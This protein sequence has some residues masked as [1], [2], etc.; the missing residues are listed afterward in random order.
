MDFAKFDGPATPSTA[1]HLRQRQDDHPLRRP[2]DPEQ[3]VRGRHQD[4]LFLQEDTSTPIPSSSWP[5]TT[6]GMERYLAALQ[7]LVGELG[8]PDVHF[9]GHIEFAE[10]L[11]FYR[12][13]R[14]LPEHERARGVRRPAPRGVPQKDPGHRLRRRGGRGDDERRRGRSCARR[15]SSGRPPSSTRSTGTPA[16]GEKIVAGQLQAL[17]KFSRENVCRILLDHVERVAGR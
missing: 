3:E 16:S 8:L 2:G 9:T 15:I 14:C 1:T 6:A 5:A 13:G 12:A 11:A 7:D 10:L 4:L 17:E